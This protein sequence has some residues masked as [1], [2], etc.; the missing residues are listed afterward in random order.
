[1][2]DDHFYW[3]NGVVNQKRMQPELIGHSLRE[4]GSA[5]GELWKSA[6]CSHQVFSTMH[7]SAIVE[8]NEQMLQNSF[9]KG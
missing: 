7:T 6:E 4:R 9:P 8:Q 2:E 1:M 3:E 5:D